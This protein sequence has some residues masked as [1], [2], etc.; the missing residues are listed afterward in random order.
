LA[1]TAT[2]FFVSPSLFGNFFGEK[3]YRSGDIAKT[4]YFHNQSSVNF[5]HKIWTV[6]YL[7]IRTFFVLR[8]KRYPK[9][10]KAAQ[11]FYDSAAQKKLKKRL[12]SKTRLPV[13]RG[14]AAH[15]IVLA[16]TVAKKP[17]FAFGQFFC[18]LHRNSCEASPGFR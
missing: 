16:Q 6:S 5:E 13:S 17:F 7:P 10:V 3:S 2:G 4:S 9:K 12:F 11:K 8:Q 14:H 1:K 18:L 15:P